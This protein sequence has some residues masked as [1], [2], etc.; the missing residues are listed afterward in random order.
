MAPDRNVYK[1]IDVQQKASTHQ[2]DPYR[3]GP[4]KTFCRITS[5]VLQEKWYPGI[6][7]WN[8]RFFTSR[9]PT[10]LPSG[11]NSQGS[12]PISGTAPTFSGAEI[13]RGPGL[14]GCVLARPPLRC[15]SALESETP[16]RFSF[17]S[18]VDGVWW[19]NIA[20][21]SLWK[22]TEKMIQLSPEEIPPIPSLFWLV[23]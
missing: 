16:K 20:L 11:Q 1:T 18:S 21:W 5:W 23:S 6:P 10:W 12:M 17:A 15:D 8:R 4:Y 19:S 7:E 14:M 3:T 13:A 22:G 9:P 2:G